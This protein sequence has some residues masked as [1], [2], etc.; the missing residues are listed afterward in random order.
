ML[1]TTSRGLPVYYKTTGGLYWKVFTSFAPK[2]TINGVPGHSSRETCFYTHNENEMFKLIALLSSSLFWWWY[3]VTSN[4]RDL[5]PSDINNFYLPVNWDNCNELIHLGKIYVEDLN[6]NSNFLTRVHQ[7]TNIT[8]VQSFKIQKTKNIIDQI[9]CYL[10]KCYS[11]TQNELDF[12][13]NYDVK[14]RMGADSV[15]DE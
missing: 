4:L 8:Q 6:A 12:I 2:F 5:N 15:D 11:F 10:A 9:D 14:F 3:T 7:K 1:Q 13:I